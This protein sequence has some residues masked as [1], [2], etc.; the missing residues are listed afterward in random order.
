MA[1]FKKEESIVPRIV[2]EVQVMELV[3]SKT[4]NW[5]HI[6]KLKT[7]TS[8]SDECISTWLGINVKTLRS[9]RDLNKQIPGSIIEHIILLLSLFRHGAEVFGSKEDFDAWLTEKN[10]FF[11]GNSPDS[12]LSMISGIRFIDN[13]LTAMEYGDNV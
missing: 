2:S 11:D 3:K 7:L 1:N 10:F 12:Y 8:Q 6:K 13:R 9:Y 5:R 4:I